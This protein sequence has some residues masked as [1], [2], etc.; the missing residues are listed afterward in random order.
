MFGE[1]FPGTPDAVGAL[2][3]ARVEVAIEG[4]RERISGRKSTSSR[5][6]ALFDG[7]MGIVSD[8]L[9]YACVMHV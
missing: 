5:V 8:V 3:V 2:T 7:G 4:G 9:L 1:L 6:A